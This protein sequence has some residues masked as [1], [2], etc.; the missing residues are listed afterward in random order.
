MATR[1]FWLAALLLI[2]ALPAQA[3]STFSASVDRVEIDGNVFGAK[4]GVPDFVDEFDNG[5]IAPGWHILVGSAT[6]EDG[7]LRI[8]DPGFVVD[9]VPGLILQVSEVENDTECDNGAGDFTTEARWVSGLPA[10][11][12]Q[13]HYQ[14]YSLGNGVE[15]SGVNV[16]HS[17][18]PTRYTVSQDVTFLL[19][20]V[21]TPQHDELDISP[22]DVTGPIVMRMAFDDASDT[23]TASFSLD[24]GQ[25]FQSPFPPM[26]VFQS[27]SD[28]ELMLGSST[29]ESIPPPPPIA[30][31]MVATK[32]LALKNSNPPAGR[33]L[34]YQI[35][36]TAA[37]IAGYPPASGAFLNITV[38]TDSQCFYMP[39]QGW[40]SMSSGFKYSDKAGLYGP[41]KQATVKRT[42]AAFAAKI[43]ALGKLGGGIAL[44]P[45][46]SGTTPVFTQLVL[47]SD[48]NAIYCGSSVGGVVKANTAK[49]FKV[50]NASAP[51]A[52]YLG[53]CS[54]SGAF[55]EDASGS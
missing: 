24:G 34:V 21:G 31:Q 7:V 19:G 8:H 28:G 35:R 1:A 20:A 11:G 36:D 16:T 40:S 42:S 50:S 9:F 55:L 38:G 3:A 18:P 22:D 23:I 43:V 5:T 45:P 15:S 49:S 48:A 25:T 29:A 32:S 33:Q 10:L 14:L 2:A 52:C 39:P 30:P 6:E 4:D 41:I 13:I 54:P 12:Q 26:H 46:I 27:M 47:G 53:T 44:T 37:V 17:G 51:L